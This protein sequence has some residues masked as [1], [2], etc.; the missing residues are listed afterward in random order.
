MSHVRSIGR[1]TVVGSH[2]QRVRLF[3]LSIELHFGVNFATF[4]VDTKE[5]IRTVR[6]LFDAVEYLFWVEERWFNLIKIDSN[7]W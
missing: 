3:L 6:L 1:C 2:Q 7:L 4:L 5:S